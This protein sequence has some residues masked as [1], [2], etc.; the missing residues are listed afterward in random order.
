M[1]PTG[2]S[3]ADYLAAHGYRNMA[4]LL[5]DRPHHK[6]H[7]WTDDAIACAE[8]FKIEDFEYNHKKSSDYQT[9]NKKKTSFF[10]AL[11]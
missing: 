2:R 1:A 10:Y 3:S 4:E 6:D 7:G 9:M 5:V 8:E 11:F